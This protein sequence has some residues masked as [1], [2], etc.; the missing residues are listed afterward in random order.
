MT[1]NANGTM[2]ATG[3]SP[4]EYLTSVIGNRSLDFLAAATAQG[5]QSPPFYLQLAV[6]APHLPAVPAPWHMNA[7]VP[8]KAPRTPNWNTGQSGKHW[9]VCGGGRRSAARR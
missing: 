9:Q 5:P 2:L 4:S 1:W 6:H 3:D 8:T 7:S